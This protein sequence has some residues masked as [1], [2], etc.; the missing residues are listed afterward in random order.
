M[1]GDIRLEI[2]ENGLILDRGINEF[3]NIV[4]AIDLIDLGLY[5]KIITALKNNKKFDLVEE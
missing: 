4:Q 5:E 1:Q 2:F 3:G